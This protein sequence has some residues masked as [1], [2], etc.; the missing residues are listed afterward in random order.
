MLRFLRTI[1]NLWNAKNDYFE[2]QVVEDQ[3]KPLVESLS[4]SYQQ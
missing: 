3:F 4:D 2:G 1:V